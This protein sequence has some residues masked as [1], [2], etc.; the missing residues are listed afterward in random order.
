MEGHLLHGFCWLQIIIT[1]EENG[2][3]DVL[4][5]HLPPL[6]VFC[7]AVLFLT[8]T[9]V[10]SFLMLGKYWF[11]FVSLVEAPRPQ[12]F[13]ALW[14]SVCSG[15]CGIAVEYTCPENRSQVWLYARACVRVGKGRID[16]G[17]S[18]ERPGHGTLWPTLAFF[19]ASGSHLWD[20][21]SLQLC[22]FL[23]SWSLVL[24]PLWQWKRQKDYGETMEKGWLVLGIHTI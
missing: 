24:T 12:P 20:A 5:C 17:A 14:A 8:F 21:S 15:S 10:N 7:L 3:S 19:W 11:F 22:T 23:S 1:V 18:G 6:S 13:N 9:V 16:T 4:W 2:Q